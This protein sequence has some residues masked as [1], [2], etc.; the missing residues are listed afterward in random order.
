M[1]RRRWTEEEDEV[2]R[3]L[4]GSVTIVEIAQR[5]GRPYPATR[6]RAWKRLGLR[7]GV[8]VPW[9]GSDDNQLQAL[10]ENHTTEELGEVLRRSKCVVQRRASALGLRRCAT[11]IPLG[12]ERVCKKRNVLQR[13]V[14]L[15]TSLPPTKRWRSV[16]S[17]VWEAAHGP[18]PPGHFVV[19]RPGM[20]THDSGLIKAD[21]LQLRTPGEQLR[22][23][24]LNAYPK[25]LR[26]VMRLRAQLDR[27]IKQVTKEMK[28]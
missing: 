12:T 3:S 25:E 9:T 10:F 1:E 8:R 6:L 23:L 26:T 14:S 20:A 27:R 17:L 4:H 28:S 22:E 18:I 7:R 15:D 16:H 21:R 11:R 13:L 5:L 19:F 24:V 2:L